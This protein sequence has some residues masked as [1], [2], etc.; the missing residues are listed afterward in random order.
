MNIPKEKEKYRHKQPQ[1]W[2]GFMSLLMVQKSQGQ[3]PFGCSSVCALESERAKAL[4]S[5][6][7]TR[8]GPVKLEKDTD[9]RWAKRWE[10]AEKWWGDVQNPPI[11]T[12]TSLKNSSILTWHHPQ[13]IHPKIEPSLHPTQTAPHQSCSSSI[14]LSQE[15]WWS[16]KYKHRKDLGQHTPTTFVGNFAHRFFWEGFIISIVTKICEHRF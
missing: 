14:H 6:L 9:Q 16:P 11:L 3:P 4:C 13:Y 7:R 12:W 10:N 8:C 1:F 5:H 2:G 15:D